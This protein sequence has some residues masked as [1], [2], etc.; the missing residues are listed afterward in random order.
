MLACP[1]MAPMLPSAVEGLAG[2]TV[3]VPEKDTSRLFL[4]LPAFDRVELVLSQLYLRTQM[5]ALEVAVPRI[6]KGLVTH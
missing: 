2:S 1:V 3:L 4:G 5:G 6:I